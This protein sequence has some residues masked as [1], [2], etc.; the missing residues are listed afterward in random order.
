MPAHPPLPPDFAPRATC[1]WLRGRV[2]LPTLVLLGVAAVLVDQAAFESL[3]D[4][5]RETLAWV[6]MLRAAGYVP[7]WLLI[8]GGIALAGCSRRSI[9]AAAQIAASAALAGGVAEIAKVLIRQARPDATAGV[10]RFI[11]WGE[12]WTRGFG[13]PSSH[14]AVA[15]GAA[16]AIAWLWPRVGVLALVVAAGCGLTRVMMGAHFVSDVVAGALVG[17]AVALALAHV[18]KRL[19]TPHASADTRSPG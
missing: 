9:V 13:L 8:A 17:Y 3:A 16:F 1:W 18:A 2:A 19:T 10:H 5:K 14:A 11:P 15:F 7:T 6:Q 4:K 12:E